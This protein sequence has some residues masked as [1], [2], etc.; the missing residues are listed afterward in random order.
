MQ[1]NPA[2]GGGIMT[3]GLQK[4]VY[5]T[6]II[7]A[8]GTGGYLVDRTFHLGIK[9]NIAGRLV[10]NPKDASQIYLNKLSKSKDK[11]KYQDQISGVIMQSGQYLDDKTK[12][13]TADELVRMSSPQIQE[14]Y[15]EIKLKQLSTEKK[16]EFVKGAL[17]QMSLDVINGLMKS[18]PDSV[19]VSVAKNIAGNQM[20]EFY[21]NAKEGVI[22]VYEATIGKLVKKD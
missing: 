14:S 20:K 22:K 10:D 21:E 17:G 16:T 13:L 19:Q 6:L 7:G 12:I 8:I 11:E 3:D 5:T 15:L 4:V 9:E 1:E 2:I 18:Q